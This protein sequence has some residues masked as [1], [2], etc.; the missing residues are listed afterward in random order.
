MKTPETPDVPEAE[1][2][3]AAQRVRDHLEASTTNID[4]VAAPVSEVKERASRRAVRRQRG[5]AVGLVAAA[6]IGVVGGVALLSQ[7]EPSRVSTSS[8]TDGADGTDDAA[9]DTV[10]GASEPTADA[11][12]PGTD[13]ADPDVIV[14]TTVVTPGASPTNTV[15]GVGGSMADLYGELGVAQ[16]A[17]PAFVWKVVDPGKDVSISG[18]FG[19]NFDSGFPAFA[20]STAPGRSN[21]Y[22]NIQTLLYRSDDGINWT[23]A[24]AQTPFAAGYWNAVVN[25]EQIFL[26]GTAPGIAETE[27]NPLQIAVGD[28]DAWEIADLP[29]DTNATSGVPMVQ[30]SGP[31][32]TAVP[33]EDGALVVVTEQAYPDFEQLLDLLDDDSDAISIMEVQDDG[34]L[35]VDSA[36]IAEQS[37]SYDPTTDLF[38][39]VD[40]SE[41][42]PTTSVLSELSDGDDYYGCPVTKRSWSEVGMPQASVD[43]LSGSMTRFFTVSADLVVAEIDGP[44]AGT[45]YPVGNNEP[46]VELASSCCTE[47]APDRYELI[48]GVWVES[49]SSVATA[50]TRQG[51]ALTELDG[52]RVGFFGSQPDGRVPF[53]SIGDDGTQR[54]VDLAPLLVT[55]AP[56]ST[57]W[58]Q[59]SASTGS[60]WV[61]AVQTHDDPVALAGGVEVA[62]GDVVVRQADQNARFELLDAASGEPIDRSLVSG[63]DNGNVEVVDEAG[64]VR[65]SFHVEDV[66]GSI[67]TVFDEPPPPMHSLLTTADGTSFAVESVAELLGV[68]E[69]AVSRVAR[70][71]TDGTGVIVTVT[72]NERYADDTR[73][74]LVLVGTPIG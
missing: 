62:F 37:G 2:H 49:S 41:S 72:L 45:Y 17:D 19:A 46:V 22:D 36:C 10:V 67:Q 1:Q 74:Q 48:D 73:K 60:L 23:Q 38:G 15:P 18:T 63:D 56:V 53:M 52:A 69:T 26:T 59:L 40:G 32:A 68:E 13:G 11:T 24:E 25:D 42:V 21:D 20:L 57:S 43:A 66:Y 55:D 27:P 29:I 12:A 9:G 71:G 16:Q 51:I 30:V 61:G 4:L 44:T 34:V 28:G 14:S 54:G 7:S 39:P 58:G 70:V 31:Q 5:V 50:L 64:A 35:W 3:R 47:E 6:S 65:A 33:Y 8:E